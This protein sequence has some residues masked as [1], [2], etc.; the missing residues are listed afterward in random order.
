M[1]RF[2]ILITVL[3]FISLSNLPAQ[4]CLPEGIIFST[5]EEIDLFQMNYPDCTEIEGNVMIQGENITNLN[6]LCVVTSIGGS[7]D[8][9][10]CTALSDLSG[11]DNVIYIGGGIS[12]C[13]NQT[14]ISLTGLEN[15]STV[16][17]D[18]IIGEVT[19]ANIKSDL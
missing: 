10:N 15:I 14:L 4:Q 5:Q 13:S 19:E 2:A 9:N 18:L 16:N 17:G 11:L 8:A 3:M 6:G 7:L 12:I 1:K